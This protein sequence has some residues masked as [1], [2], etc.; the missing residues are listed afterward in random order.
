[1]PK[2]LS[3]EVEQRFTALNDAITRNTS[4]TAAMAEYVNGLKAELQTTKD[5]LAAALGDDGDEPDT[6][7]L[8]EALANLDAVIAAIDADTAASNAVA[9]T[10]AANQP[11]A[12]ATA[13]GGLSS[14]A[15]GATSGEA[16]SSGNNP[17]RTDEDG[18]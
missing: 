18:N 12:P 11:P 4:A 2:K 17:A 16:G 10:P 6:D 7:A 8:N 3:Q 9:N 15:T 14:E 13:D 1:M 5:Q